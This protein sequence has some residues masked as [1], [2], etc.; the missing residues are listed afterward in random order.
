MGQPTVI[1]GS[2]EAAN[3]LLDGKG[4]LLSCHNAELSSARTF[5]RRRNL[6]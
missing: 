6:F 3:D 2:F 1:L 4:E 5:L